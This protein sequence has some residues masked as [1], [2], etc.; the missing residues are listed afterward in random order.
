M[1]LFADIFGTS[2]STFQIEIGGVKL[3]NSAGN[4]IVKDSAA[5]VSDITVKKPFV[6]GDEIELNSDAAGSVADWKYLIARPPTGMTEALTLVLPP[7]HGAANQILQT[8][9]DNAYTTSWVDPSTT[10]PLLTVDTTTLNWNS[11]AEVAMFTLPVGAVVDRVKVVIDT[12]FDGTTAATMSVG[13]T[14][15]GA[16]KYMAATLVNLKGTAKDVYESNPGEVPVAG[17]PESLVITFAA[18]SGGAPSA[19]VARVFVFYVI[20][21]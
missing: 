21:G 15:A 1:G 8:S 7:T 18:A 5:A 12:P 4:L 11:A 17:S 10:T 19:G 3:W 13:T 16:A 14:G 20:P 9:G 6:Q 2:K